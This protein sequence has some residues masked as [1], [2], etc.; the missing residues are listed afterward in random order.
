MEKFYTQYF[1]EVPPNATRYFPGLAE[2]TA[3]FLATKV[4]DHMLFLAKKDKNSVDVDQSGRS[5]DITSTTNTILSE[6]EHSG[7]QYLGGYVF[8][9]LHKKLKNSPKWKSPEYQQAISVLEAAR[10]TDIDD[11]KLVSCLNRGGLWAINANAQVI[12]FKTENLFRDLTTSI[13][14]NKV[15]VNTILFR[16]ISHAPRHFN[17]I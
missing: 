10:T 15:D 2:K 7:G 12:I 3:T 16:S 5:R 9:N 6:R 8:H 1:S 11:Q 17:S 13:N 4:A 14:E